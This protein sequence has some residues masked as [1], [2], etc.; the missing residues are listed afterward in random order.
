MVR[1]LSVL[2]VGLFLV[3]GLW[4]ASA[5]DSIIKPPINQSYLYLKGKVSAP[6]MFKQPL[7]KICAIPMHFYLKDENISAM[8][9]YDMD[10]FLDELEKKPIVMPYMICANNDAR[11]IYYLKLK[12]GAYL[13]KATAKGFT[14]FNQKIFI[15]KSMVLDIALKPEQIRSALY[16]KVVEDVGLM[17]V[18]P[19]AIPFAE[20]CVKRLQLTTIFQKTEPYR[21]MQADKFGNFKFILQDGIYSVVGNAKGYFKR[22][23]KVVVKDDTGIMLPLKHMI[24][25]R[26][27]T[28][29]K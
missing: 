28:Q 19:K 16:G 24:Y 15:T 14:E 22:E 9:N 23:M 25:F 10:N 2:F 8:Q 5:R 21:C 20:V 6:T 26:Q 12:A 27:S 11:G 18:M 17:T 4:A 3:T 29:Q 1:F 7:A 13:I